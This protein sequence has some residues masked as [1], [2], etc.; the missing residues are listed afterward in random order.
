MKTIHLDWSDTD[1]VSFLL[2]TSG[3]WPFE[4]EEITNALIAA[5]Y[6]KQT[7]SHFVS[8]VQP[9]PDGK[10]RIT[11]ELE[12]IGYAVDHGDDTE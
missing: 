8:V 6:A 2:R 12:K 11:A 3:L 1:G 10:E 5:G 7:V 4:V 9:R